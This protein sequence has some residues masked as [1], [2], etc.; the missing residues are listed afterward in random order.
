MKRSDLFKK[1]R[2]A[3][4]TPPPRDAQDP[5]KKYTKTSHSVSY[6]TYQRKP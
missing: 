2:A 6:F 5:N 3:T 4:A 1:L